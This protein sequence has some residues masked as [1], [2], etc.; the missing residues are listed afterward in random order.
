M[1]T[2]TTPR[3]KMDTLSPDRRR[4]IEARSAE[5]V[6]EELSLRDLRH[7]HKLTQA[8]VAEV[9]GMAQEGVSRLEKRVDLLISTLRGYVEAMGGHLRLVAEF[10]D[11]PPV[12]LT[13]LAAM[14]DDA[15]RSSLAGRRRRGQTRRIAASA[16][17]KR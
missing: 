6:A 4:K 3:D 15:A 12:V 13:G 14:E 8:E 5:L 2:V 16:G 11:R 7:A 10:P 17:R 1:I 9:L